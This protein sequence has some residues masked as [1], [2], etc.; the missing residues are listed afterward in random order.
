[1]TKIFCDICGD[2]IT[3]FSAVPTPITTALGMDLC[4]ECGELVCVIDW[5]DIIR[6]TVLDVYNEL[7]E[8]KNDDV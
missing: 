4:E 7:E 3:G 6:G 1:M 8:G 5:K 2:E